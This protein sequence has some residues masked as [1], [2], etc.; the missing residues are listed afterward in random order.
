MVFALCTPFC[1]THLLHLRCNVSVFAFPLMRWWR[2]HETGAVLRLLHFCIG[3]NASATQ[4]QCPFCSQY[5]RNWAYSSEAW[6][7]PEN[8][9]GRLKKKSNIW[10]AA[11]TVWV[12]FHL[13]CLIVVGRKMTMRGRLCMCVCRGRGTALRELRK[14]W[15]SQSSSRFE[16]GG[17]EGILSA[18]L[19]LVSAWERFKLTL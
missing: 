8:C 14:R 10:W 1:S 7:G 18:K 6:I 4:L 3:I 11:N 12:F 16:D 15:F 13:L 5:L 19:Q 2:C 17:V 9:D